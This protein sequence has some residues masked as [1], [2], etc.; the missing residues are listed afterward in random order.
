MTPQR[1][2]A[3]AWIPPSWFPTSQAPLKP[4]AAMG[5]QLGDIFMFDKVGSDYTVTHKIE[6]AHAGEVLA[7]SAAAGRLTGSQILC[8]K[9]IVKESTPAVGVPHV[10][11][12]CD[13]HGRRSRRTGSFS[14][15]SGVRRFVLPQ[16]NTASS[17][18]R[19][20]KIKAWDPKLSWREPVGGGGGGGLE[21]LPGGTGDGGGSAR[22]GG[23]WGGEHR[24]CSLAGLQP[25]VSML[26]SD[27]RLMR[28]QG[29]TSW[30]PPPA[31][32][33]SSR[34]ASRS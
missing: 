6:Q 11:S 19:D 26:P 9:F 20:G 30:L 24:G 34:S 21:G 3:I 25:E 22:R 1:A 14:I 31:S 28:R 17:G 15:C 4:V 33:P 32:T 10:F 7:A 8:L 12:A 2:F 5:L 29:R 13:P 23:G 16:L 18:G 27:S